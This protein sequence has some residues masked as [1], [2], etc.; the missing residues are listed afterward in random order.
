MTLVEDLVYLNRAKIQMDLNTLA[1]LPWK[2]R[3]ELIKEAEE[4]YKAI[5]K[6]I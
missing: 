2:M 4:Y 6:K 3:Y 5:T 1:K